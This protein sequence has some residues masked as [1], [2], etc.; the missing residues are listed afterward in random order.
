MIRWNTVGYPFGV[1]VWLIWALARTAIA[2]AKAEPQ[3]RDQQA[4]RATQHNKIACDE[5]VRGDRFRMLMGAYGH[6]LFREHDVIVETMLIARVRE[7]SL[8]DGQEGELRALLSRRMLEPFAYL[9]G[10]SDAELL[11]ISFALCYSPDRECARWVA[12]GLSAA[13]QL[14]AD[15]IHPRQLRRMMYRHPGSRRRN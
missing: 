13:R 12:A 4:L 5:C 3:P 10:C 8:D 14:A 9:Q 6:A 1:V 11:D 15:A 2:Q 7:G